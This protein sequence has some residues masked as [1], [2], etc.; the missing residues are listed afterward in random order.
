MS[1][2]SKR[3]DKLEAKQSPGVRVWVFVQTPYNRELY[4]CYDQAEPTNDRAVTA[5]EARA[6]TGPNDCIFWITC[7]EEGIEAR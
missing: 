3:V 6:L 5:E 4:R 7:R 2:L 1:D